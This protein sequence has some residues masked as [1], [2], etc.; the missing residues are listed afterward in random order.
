MRE[1]YTWNENWSDEIWNHDR[2]DTIEEC[3]KDAVENYGKKPGDKIVIGICEDYE[4]HVDVGTI[5]DRASEDAYETCGEVA[6]GWPTFI[7]LKGYA[8]EDKL[9]EKM[10]KAFR[11]WLEET[12]QMPGFYH[13][14]PLDGQFVIPGKEEQYETN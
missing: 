5:L 1:K 2:F 14:L 9:Q 10:D 6:E 12:N 7:R 3:V 4:P 8:D 11:E 13:I